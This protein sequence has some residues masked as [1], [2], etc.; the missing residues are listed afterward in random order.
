MTHPHQLPYSQ[1][2]YLANEQPLMGMPVMDP[3]NV[4]PML[5]QLMMP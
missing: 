2:M 5:P 1:S 3:H 4:Q